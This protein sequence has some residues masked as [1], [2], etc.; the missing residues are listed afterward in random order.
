MIYEFGFMAGNVEPSA[1]CLFKHETRQIHEKPVGWSWFYR[2]VRRVAER[3]AWVLS[4]EGNEGNKA[5][6]GHLRWLL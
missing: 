6:W 2:R 3:S 1:R 4:T 5:R